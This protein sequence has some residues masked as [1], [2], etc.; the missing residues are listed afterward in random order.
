M[1]KL[2]LA[3]A[4]AVSLSLAAAPALAD[5]AAT[6]IWKAKCKGCHGDTG[7][8]DTKE[9]RKHKA[10][11]MTTEEWQAKHDD[12]E[13]KDAIMNGVKDTKMKAYKDKYSEAEIDALIRHIRTLKGQ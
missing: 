11:D 6:D 8:G 2:S 7:K 3:A 1:K 10:P 12:A 13:L 5:E 4:I 9:G